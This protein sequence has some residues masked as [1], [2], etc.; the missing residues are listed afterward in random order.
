MRKNSSSY[1][2]ETAQLRSCILIGHGMMVKRDDVASDRVN[3]FTSGPLLST[4]IKRKQESKPS[5][6]CSALQATST[7]TECLR[8]WTGQPRAPW[9]QPGC[10]AHLKLRHPQQFC[11]SGKMHRTTNM[12]SRQD[13]GIHVH[14]PALCIL[15]KKAGLGLLSRHPSG[16]C[17]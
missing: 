7:M 13:K 1:T 10:Q 14:M 12:K 16:L 9:K 3:A 15:Q 17:G 5:P 6:S 4:I 8:S 11:S 2:V